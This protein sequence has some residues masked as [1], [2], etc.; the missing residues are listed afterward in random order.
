MVFFSG[1]KV[2][3]L[4]DVHDITLQEHSVRNPT[5]NNISDYRFCIAIPYIEEL[6]SNINNHF[7]EASDQLLTSSAIFHP[8]SIPKEEPDILEYG[9]TE[10][11]NLVGF[12][13]ILGSDLHIKNSHW[14]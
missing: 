1:E 3:E 7:L 9:R 13:G 2:A 12:Y 10:M 4:T 11:Q 5:P 8:A 6:V 14:C